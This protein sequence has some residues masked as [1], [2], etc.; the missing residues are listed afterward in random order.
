SPAGKFDLAFLPLVRRQSV[1]LLQVLQHWLGRSI[2]LVQHRD[3]RPADAIP[4][5][6]TE[7]GHLV[8]LVLVEG[9]MPSCTGLSIRTARAT[10][11]QATVLGALIVVEQHAGDLARMAVLLAAEDPARE[12]RPVRYDQAQ[13]AVRLAHV[14]ALHVDLLEAGALAR[15]GRAGQQEGAYGHRQ[16]A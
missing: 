13:R 1:Q 11:D 8:L 7:R 16:R 15:C 12:T 6:L 9:K 5:V 4:F 3:S 10:K 14:D 2:G